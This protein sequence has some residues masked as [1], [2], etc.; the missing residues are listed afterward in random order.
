M[1]TLTRLSSFFQM[2]HVVANPGGGVGTDPE[3]S[4]HFA[5]PHVVPVSDLR[6]TA[7]NSNSSVQEPGKALMVT[8]APPVTELGLVTE[9][10]LENGLSSSNI[11]V[12]GGNK[13]HFF[14]GL[15]SSSSERQK[16]QRAYTLSFLCVRAYG[17]F[18]FADKGFP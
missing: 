1:D 16:H 4:G 14:V 8:E 2:M 9:S 18:S 5:P 7:G 3:K 17:H 11:G 15:W 10:P 6:N 12:I 13:I